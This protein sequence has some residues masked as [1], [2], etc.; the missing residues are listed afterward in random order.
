MMMSV[1]VTTA[2]SPDICVQRFFL[3]LHS[4]QARS[5]PRET[6]PAPAVDTI[7]QRSTRSLHG[8]VSTWLS[9][10]VIPRRH[11]EGLKEGSDDADQEI[12]L[13]VAVLKDGSWQT[14]ERTVEVSKAF[15]CSL[16]G[17]L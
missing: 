9:V 1:Y 4:A 6:R 14:N 12:Y 16:P 7:Y 11:C 8:D 5:L 3:D 10:N 15:I 17:C 13:W 2:W